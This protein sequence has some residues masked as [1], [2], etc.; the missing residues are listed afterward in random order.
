MLLDIREL[1][2]NYGQ[3]AAIK[4]ISMEIDQKEIVTLIGPN[5]AGKTT[6]MRTISGLKKAM[7]GVIF[8]EEERIDNKSP[9]KILKMGIAHVPEGRR[10]FPFISVSDNLDLGAYT[11]KDHTEI[12]KDREMIFYH[13]PILKNRLRQRAGSLSGG[14]QQ[15]LAIG[16]ALMSKPVLLLLDEP[17]LGLAPKMVSEVGRIIQEINKLSVA[18]ILV[19]QNA[20][21]ALRVSQRGYVI[22]TGSI[23]LSSDRKGLIENEDVKKAYLGI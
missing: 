7:K 12:K 19:E 3:V 6:L 20:N 15:M 2:V 4:G 8:F 14:E 18:I 17:S 13:F 9:Q 22:T 23:V 11:R 16:R 10:I 5:G 1:Q 21:M